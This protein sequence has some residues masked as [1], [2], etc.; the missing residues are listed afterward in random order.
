MRN[1]GPQRPG[2]GGKR[3]RIGKRN[4]S[5][6]SKKGGDSKGTFRKKD[7]D[8]DRER[9]KKTGARYPERKSV[10]PVRRKSFSRSPDDKRST[11]S[12]PSSFGNARKPYEKK[13]N[14]KEKHEFYGE[15]KKSPG[16]Y[17]SA[18]PAPV[19]N[20]KGEIRL[21]KFISNAGVC[22]RREADG[23]IEA[24]VISVN[25]KIITTLGYKVQP[26]DEV[27]YN[28]VRLKSEKPMYVLLN[29]PKDFI[30]TVDDPQNRSTVM[31]LV[32]NACKERIYPVGRLDRNTTGLL[33][34]TNDGELADCLTHPGFEVQKVY[35]VHLDKNLKSEHLEEIRAGIN[36]EDGFIR[37]DDISYSPLSHSVVGIELHS[38][39]NRIVRRIFESFGYSVRKLDRVLYAGLTKK[40]LPRGKWRFLSPIELAHLK[41]LTGK[42]RTKPGARRVKQVA[43]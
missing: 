36:L 26:G 42:K 6:F 37:P 14:R 25:G 18:R 20:D 28:D 30:T 13:W 11:E 15:R 2:R 31:S 43:E 19:E 16:R 3:P 27:R 10:G 40:D 1:Q 12:G 35:E 7:S 8:E 38:G 21:N 29:K 23:L 5:T 41:M 39:R 32:R 9:P 22:S 33:L 4:E 17:A 34:F 24:G